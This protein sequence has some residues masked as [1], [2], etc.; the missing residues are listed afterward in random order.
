MNAALGADSEVEAVQVG[1]AKTTLGDLQEAAPLQLLQVCTDAAVGGA[2]VFRKLD[3]PWKAGV[4]VPGIL[5]KHRVSEL[6]PDRY[7]FVG[8][9]E[10]GDLG[11]A[12]PGDGI[13]TDEFNIAF[14][15]DVANAPW[16]R[17]HGLH[18][19]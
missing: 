10:V 2:H 12:V 6:S 13:G 16:L 14:F 18:Y 9:H 3:L 4:V 7:I 15:E 8:E 19:T 1:L 5:E 17:V 11:E